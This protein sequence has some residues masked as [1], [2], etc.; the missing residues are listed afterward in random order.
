MT[1][2]RRYTGTKTL[3]TL[4]TVV[5]GGLVVGLEGVFPGL[6][7]RLATVAGASVVWLLGLVGLGL[8]DRRRW[9]RLTAASAFERGPSP[10]TADLQ[11]IRHGQS[12]AV[13]T[14]IP[15][16]LSQTH[17]SVRANVEGVDAS[18]T[19]RIR[20]SDAADPESGLTT[21]DEGLDRRF[22]IEGTPENVRVLLSEPVRTALLDVE[23]PGTFTVTGDAVVYEIPFTRLRPVELDAAAEAV[24]VLAA[25]VEAVS[26]E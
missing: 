5:I 20:G 16:V 25:R 15:G 17:T 8:Y 18:F 22:V 12:V 4:W 7:P 11:G 13:T 3:Q 2:W 1:D 10:N 14:D 26:S 21:G 9:R 24:A 23:T 19:V 6:A